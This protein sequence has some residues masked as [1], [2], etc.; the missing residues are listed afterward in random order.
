[1]E[2]FY[3]ILRIFGGYAWDYVRDY[4][5]DYVDC[6]RKLEED[7]SEFRSEIQILKSKVNSRI[8]AEVHSGQVV[9]EE[10][11]G[12]FEDVQKIEEDLLDV[13]ERARR[14]S[15]FQRASLDKLVREKIEM[16]KRIQERGNFNEGL[17]T[18]RAPAPGSRIPTEKL[19][20]E[21]STKGRIWEYLMGDEVGMIGVCGIGGVGK[22]TIMKHVNNDLLT[23]SIFQK[24]IWVTVS[25]PFNVFE[26]QEKIALA[27]GKSK[28]LEKVK[29]ETMRAAALMDI[30]G[31]LRF[32]LILDDVWEKFSFSDVGIP[33]PVQNKSKVV[34]TTRSI[35]VC[36]YLDCKIVKVQ[37]L[38]PEESLNLFLE[39]VG[40]DVLQNVS[41]L[42]ET[43]KP[44][45]AE[46]KGLPLAIV[47][48]AG[49]LKGEYDIAEWRNA[50]NELRQCVTSVKCVEDEI[51]VRL[52]FS[53]DRL[54]S[55]QIQECFLYCS[56]FRE[57]YEFSEKKLIED[58][59]DEGLIVIAELGSRQAAYDRGHAFLN[60]LLQNCLL[61]ECVGRRT[62]KMHDVVRDMAIKSIGPG[63][64]YMVKAGMKLT[65]VPNERGWGND[66]KKVSL[67]ANEISKIPTGLSPKCP[68]LTTLILS[69][70]LNLLEIPSSFFEDMVGLKVLDLSY[71]DIEAL[72]DSISNLVNLS[73]L[74]L[75][76]CRSLKY[77]PS[78]AK[79][80]ALKKLD[81]CG[82]GIEAVPEGMEM[83]VSL[84]YL[85]L[86]CRNLKEIPSSL[87]ESVVGL[88]VL[89]LSGTGVK[90]LPNSI[91]NLVNL[92]T[93]RLR[94]C[95]R[96]KYLPSFEK[97]M[98]LKK[99][100][101]NWAGIEVVPQGMEMLV[102]L[103][104]LDL[105]CRTLKEIPTGILP[106]L[107][108]L[109]YL[110]VYPSSAITKR[111]HI[112]EVARLSNLESLKCGMEVQGFNYLINK[113]KDFDSLTAY[114]LRLTT[115]EREIT[116]Y[117]FFD[118]Y[119]RKV[120]IDGWEIGEE[121]VVLPDTLEDLWISRCKNMKNM[122]CSLNKTVLLENA[123]ELRRCRID[124]CEGIECMVELDSSSSS[125]CRLVL[126]KLED[127]TLHHLSNLS[128]LVRVEGVT[129]PLH[130]FS[131]L[132]YLSIRF[133]SAMRKLIP[134]ELLRALQNLMGITVVGC[135]QMEEIIETIASSDSDASSSNKFP[136]TF[137]KLHVLS[138]ME[139]Y[140]LKSICSGKGVMVCDSIKLIQI[141]NCPELE[142]IP[143]QLPLL[144][145]GQP[146]PPPCLE[147]IKIDD[148]SKEW[149]ESVVEWDHS[150]AK[151]ILQPF[152]EFSPS[153]NW[154]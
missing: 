125:L 69:W 7:L 20:G 92:S 73:A 58:W 102:S 109:Q 17:V 5:W 47:V 129:T 96:L 133:C 54:R 63:F 98:A 32:V 62:V 81:L 150:N 30:M 37:P 122:R 40:R 2:A 85:D 67:M 28:T 137:P 138:L 114:E 38:S 126:D 111:I 112:E 108:S 88:Q 61:E 148:K 100:D 87:F 127:L 75:R 147:K 31:E 118:V 55:L 65:E 121:C 46:C 19:E 91:S 8:Q 152:L 107:S 97:L 135:T 1:M 143:F 36:K 70:N 64:G 59:I 151:N 3:E 6:H 76:E 52:R 145:N 93:L 99:L 27:M 154:G 60:R 57:D 149:W 49:S 29:E 128:A 53:Y 34:I 35:E 83:L 113:S 22:T 136:F 39:K 66:I 119:P 45:V 123:T 90:A 14:I 84:E 103:K 43:L 115:G 21:I 105:Y 142:R 86:S 41:G 25:Y 139:L 132:K 24:V 153:Y 50:L 80:G 15:Y 71:T 16:L 134:L 116:G 11:R 13:E 51:F 9:R 117:G 44:I 74:R 130:I 110:A 18:E 141:S 26:L 106:S 77:L 56:L 79:L 10:E 4:V 140:Q 89:D 78:L 94:K 48:I 42:E 33:E 82:A 104:Y 12:W 68:L 120:L 95:Q 144:A 146:S 101:L 23:G 124:D 72:P 131:N